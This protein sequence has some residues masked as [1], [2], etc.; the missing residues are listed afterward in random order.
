MCRGTYIKKTLFNSVVLYKIAGILYA[1][2]LFCL[3]PYRPDFW[4]STLSHL[5]SNTDR[6]LN[7][8]RKY[9]V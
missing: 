4:S 3:C 8:N 2:L 7:S 9:A 6:I 5:K 1:F